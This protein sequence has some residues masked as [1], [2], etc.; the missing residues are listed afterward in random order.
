MTYFEH[1][2]VAMGRGVA[3][4]QIQAVPLKAVIGRMKD[5]QD[6]EAIR[7]ILGDIEQKL[8]SLKVEK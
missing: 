7:A 1:V 4:R 2:N 8:T 3:L 6:I 5:E